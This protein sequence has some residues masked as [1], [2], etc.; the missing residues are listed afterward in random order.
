MKDLTKNI[1]ALN[2]CITL[3]IEKI[4]IED[5]VKKKLAQIAKKSQID[6][7]RPG[8]APLHIIEQRH[9]HSVRQDVINELMQR[10]LMDMMI[11]NQLYPS[12]SPVY[13][14]LESTN[15]T[16][17]TFSVKFDVYPAIEI[18]GIENIKIEK[19]IIT[20]TESDVDSMIQILRQQKAIW[21]ETNAPVKTK[22]R[23]TL[24]FSGSKNN[25]ALSNFKESNL[26][27]IIGDGQMISVFEEGIIG[28]KTGEHF[29]NEV[30]F[31]KNYNNL[32]LQGQTIKFNILVK[33]VETYTLP[34]I[35][36]GFIKKF[37][38][39]EG[40]LKKLRAE[41]RQNMQRELNNAVR[42]FIKSQVVTGLV[43]TNYIEIPDEIVNSKMALLRNQKNNNY[44][45][46]T[47]KKENAS[48]VLSFEETKYSILV[49]LLFSQV[50]HNFNITANKE[51][52]RALIE[53]IASAYDDPREVITQYQANTELMKN[54]YN[55]DLE[56]QAVEAILRKA[57]IIEKC[58]TF[59]DFMYPPI[60]H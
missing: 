5:T 14:A 25:R 9:G 20:V 3:T 31:P 51:R 35:N 4:V 24:K 55:T 15:D 50:I 48:Q 38:V 21:K 43:Q 34:E 47:K 41:V 58:T 44:Y 2:K 40:S 11:K 10:Y 29:T 60:Q 26:V 33:K 18:K 27:L 53:E 28:H 17:V 13:I 56:E 54:I 12:S 59:E 6:G 32:E 46:T 30:Y 19:P 42:H 37:G 49:N 23:V 52:V 39:K 7:F 8:K 16:D 45:N 1:Q 22:D 57:Q 36:T